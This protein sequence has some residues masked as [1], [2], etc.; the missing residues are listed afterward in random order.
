MRRTL[1][2]LFC[3]LVSSVAFAQTFPREG[4]P[5]DQFYKQDSKFSLKFDSTKKGGT[6]TWKANRQE[7]VQ[8]DYA[9]L[10]GDV[11]ISYQDVT[12]T[13][14]RA[15]YNLKTKDATAEGHV[16]LDQGPRRLTADRAVYNLESQTGTLFDATGAFE[17]S[18]YFTGEKIEKLNQST[19]RLTN[20]LF[21]SCDLDNPSWSFR[22]SSGTITVD[23]YARLKDLSFRAHKV[24]LFYT[25]YLKWP[26]KADR[27]RGFLIPRPG[28]SNQYGAFLREQYFIPFGKHADTTIDAEWYSK[29]YWALGDEIRY[30]PSVNTTGDIRGQLVWDEEN[31]KHEW[32]YLYQHAQDHLPGDIRGVI[33]I[34]DFSD[35][36]F[37]QRFER[38]FEL[39]TLSYVYSSAYLTKNRPG[40]SMNLRADR[41]EQFLGGTDSIVNST[42]PIFEFREYPNRI[43][44]SP[45]YM[46]IDSSAG[47]LRTNQGADYYRADFSPTLTMQLATPPWLSIKPQL[48]VRETYYTSSL[49]PLTREIIDDPLN[50]LYAQGQ[51]EFVG[52]SFSRI[53]DK[54][55]ASFT[56][57]K[58]VIEP[59][60]RYVHTTDV[61]DQSQVIKFDTVDSPFLPLVGN[62]LE[63]SLTQR[64]LGKEK[65]PDASARDIM[66]L[67][68]GQSV[69]LSGAFQP[70]T[71]ITPEQKFSDLFIRA[72]V[73]PYQ[74]FTV[75][76]NVNV[77]NLSHQ[78]SSTNVSARISAATRYLD[79]TWFASYLPPG[80]LYGESSQ[81]RMSGGSPLVKDKIRAD[82]QLNFDAQ[83][84]E[85]LDQVYRLGTFASCYAISFEY[86]D[87]LQLGNPSG[88]T[89]SK[90]YQISINLKNVGTFVDLKGSLDRF[91]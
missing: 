66:S 49:S 64:V 31:Q 44:K 87:F 60:V 8:E 50:R 71:E 10:E 73:N 7:F 63:Y 61:E 56:K 37:F 32:K 89:R 85:F 74:S 29:G 35:L 5:S 76:A 3:L 33:D 90:D 68:F 11:K 15:T 23:D 55:V 16:I 14:D 62:L 46:S 38:R 28:Y 51:V 82:V 69:A 25:P 30:K 79:M 4:T 58:H 67:T 34:Q 42:L 88:P 9:V 80:Q 39:N 47:H 91:F 20:G 13:A 36:N 1:A 6:V 40:Y 52:P 65:G 27:S 84:G 53:F 12:I 57:L 22:L 17:P 45:F 77:D 24:P 21:T 70:E 18:I 26:T 81:I 48:T 2:I 41:R 43:G 75:D 72:H 19:Y 78:I 83:S 54:Q 59:R 86:R